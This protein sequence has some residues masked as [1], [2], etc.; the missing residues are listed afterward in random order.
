MW[1]GTHKNERK[2]AKQC[3]TSAKSVV[4]I[5]LEGRFS[6]SARFANGRCRKRSSVGPGRGC[7]EREKKCKKKSG[8][9]QNNPGHE[10][11]NRDIFHEKYLWRSESETPPLTL[12]HCPFVFLQEEVEIEA[13]WGGSQKK[14]A[15]QDAFLGLPGFEAGAVTQPYL[16]NVDEQGLPIGYARA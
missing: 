2:R 3:K 14:P 4:S 5:A 12:Y 8:I 13:P 6:F 7:E 16:L 15:G 9:V 1:A 11:Q 10:E